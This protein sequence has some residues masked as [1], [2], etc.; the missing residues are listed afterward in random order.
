MVKK[1]SCSSLFFP[2]FSREAYGP[3][4]FLPGDAGYKQK[5]GMKSIDDPAMERYDMVC[6]VSDSLLTM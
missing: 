6:D 2:A 4:G 1:N 3:E 5:R